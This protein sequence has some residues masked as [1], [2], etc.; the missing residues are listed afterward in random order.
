MRAGCRQPW[1]RIHTVNGICTHKTHLIKKRPPY[2]DKL[3]VIEYSHKKNNQHT[4]QTTVCIDEIVP[5][6]RLG[7]LY[8]T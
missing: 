8:C 5:I 7:W 2:L 3:Y 1:M 6:I 4:T